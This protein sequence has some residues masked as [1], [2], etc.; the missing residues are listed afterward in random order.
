EEQIEQLWEDAYNAF[1]NNP[2]QL[3]NEQYFMGSVILLKSKSK[4]F[5]GYEIVDGQQRLVTFTILLAV[6]RDHY[7][8][9]EYRRRYGDTIISKNFNR[10]R[11]R[12][13][14]SA[15]DQGYFGNKIQ[16]KVQLP[17]KD[18]IKN[19]FDYAI[20]Y[21]NQKLGEMRKVDGGS[22]ISRFT[23]YIFNNIIFI[24][25]VCEDLNDAILLFQIQNTR[26]LELSNS[27]LI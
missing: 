5:I 1:K 13:M 20:W 2:D 27:D 26:G 23:D 14:M 25:I 24:K 19:S 12:L 22:S 10:E 21:F 7:W 11:I 6:L 16:E 17:A 9:D 8:D 18:E 3:E 15:S 4:D